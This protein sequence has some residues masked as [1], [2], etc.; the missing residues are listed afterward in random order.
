MS[1]SVQQFRNSPARLRKGAQRLVPIAVLV[2]LLCACMERIPAPTPEPTVT[3]NPSEKLFETPTPISV[4]IGSH[5]S[6]AYN[7]NWIMW[8]EFEKETGAKFEIT[9][10]PNPD[11]ELRVNLM[12]ATKT[13]I[14]DL[15]FVTSKGIISQNAESG[16]FVNLNNY[17][18]S[19]PNFRA[20]LGSLGAE[21]AQQML[22][23]HSSLG[24]NLY[25]FPN[26]GLDSI[27]NLRAWMY[28]KDIFE[29]HGLK[30]PTTMEELY[31]VCKKL[32]AL[33]P[34]SYPLS[35]R[36]GVNLLDVI[37]S[38]WKP[39]FQTGIY[40]DF[41]TK[42]WHYGATEDIMKDLIRY[43]KR[44]YDEKLIP[45]DFVTINVENWQGMVDNNQGFL[46]PEYIARLDFFNQKNR[47]RD[48]KYTWA[49]MAPPRVYDNVAPRLE[50]LNFEFSGYVLC[51]T[52]NQER[53]NNALKLVDWMYSPN[54][55]D[56]MSWGI[57]GKTYR[58]KDGEKEFILDKSGASP[59]TLYGIGTYGLYQVVEEAAN[60]ALYSDENVAG[61]RIAIQHIN[62]NINPSVWL[63][64]NLAENN[65][66]R[67]IFDSLEN[68]KREQI[69]AFILGTQPLSA[70]DDFQAGLKARYV[71]QYVSL[72]ASAYHRIL[73]Q[74]E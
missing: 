21:T 10:V 67:Q 40:Y 23:E 11:F 13:N 26:Y 46:M 54:G 35:I 7:P 63:P 49:V 71:D 8:D 62:P 68:Y 50:K 19:L 60:E 6:W 27:N 9:A 64:L 56:L 65:A 61:A 12:L 14:P 43:F 16:S 59:R 45:P 32:K 73:A 52:Q 44:M 70:W 41:E 4:M 28:R 2:L 31:Q 57:E 55:V 42:T 29:K 37:G 30:V 22:L 24:S 36:M 20:F 66:I 74:N 53:I 15:I 48:P 58:V 34:D 47:L 5:S 38:Q 3:E 17:M 1:G 72:C 39:Y 51:N 33:Y 25:M 69:C 18:D